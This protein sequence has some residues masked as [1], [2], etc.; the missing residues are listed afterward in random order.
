MED[1]CSAHIKNGHYEEGNVALPDQ[2]SFIIEDT[3]LANAVLEANH[4]C[5]VGQTGLLCMPQYIL[6]NVKFQAS[7]ILSRWL[8]FNNH[9]RGDHNYVQ[10]DGGIFSLSPRD[11]KIV[12]EGGDLEASI[13]PDGYVSAISSKFEYLL[14]HPNNVCDRSS[15]LGTS[16][17]RRYDSGILCRVPLRAL[18]VYSRGLTTQMKPYDLKVEVWFNGSRESNPH[19]IQNIRYHQ[20][21]P[22]GTKRQG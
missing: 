15:I 8:Y 4:H 3:H 22:D 9:V 21:G 14:S 17:E 6:H 16:I 18:K 19:A 2:A 13:F 7:S 20:S 11:A 5:T 10:N 1:G 12:M